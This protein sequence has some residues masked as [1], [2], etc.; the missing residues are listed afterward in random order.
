M[1]PEGLVVLVTGGRDYADKQR[2]FLELD[3]L[4]REQGPIA[5]IVCGACNDPDPERDGEMRGA[6]RWAIEWAVSRQVDFVGRPARWRVDGYPQAGPMRNARML[7]QHRPNVVMAF[8]GGR[9]T[10]NCCKLAL[11]AGVD[12]LSF[13]P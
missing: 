8:G 4:D 11:E 3:K 5:W 10:D 6:D 9:G 1:K 2:V 7:A 12:V 13:R